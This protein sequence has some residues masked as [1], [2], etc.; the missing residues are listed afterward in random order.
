ME[1]IEIEIE[2]PACEGTGLYQGLGEGKGTAVVCYKCNGSGKY[3][4]LYSYNKFTG[5]KKKPDIERVY[6]SGYGYKIGLGKLLFGGEIEID[7]DNEGVSYDEFLAG[8]IPGHIE[9][10]ACPML[11]DQSA[12][13]K[14]NGFTDKCSDLNGSS[15]WGCHIKGCRNYKNKKECWK[16]FHNGG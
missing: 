13:Q 7:M 14:I 3:L 4:Y 15:L 10:L 8:K 2:C 1:K 16:R 11:A 9:E 5:R 12:C 6:L